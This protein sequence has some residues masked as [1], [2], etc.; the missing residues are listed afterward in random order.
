[1]NR[2]QRTSSPTT[3]VKR[4]KLL[5]LLLVIVCQQ[6]F[7]QQKD[8]GV[9]TGL[10]L[11]KELT[12]RWDFSVEVGYRQKDNLNRRDKT[13]AGAEISWSRKF[14]KTAVLYRYSNENGMKRISNSHRFGFETQLKTDIDRFTFSYR[15]RLQSEYTNIQSSDRGHVPDSFFRN[16]AKVSYNIKGIPLEPWLSYELFWRINAYSSQQIERERMSAGFGYKFNKHHAVGVSFLLN[17]Q[18]NVS[19][20]EDAYILALD[21]QF[22]LPHKKK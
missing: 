21:Y 14:L 12:K 5:T 13:F 11:E 2:R 8:F 15:G 16:R 18:K 19:N 17:R 20:P 9:W 3:N 22:K 1:M 6:A 10:T 4:N 7:A